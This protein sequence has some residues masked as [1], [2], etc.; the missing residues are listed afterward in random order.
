MTSHRSARYGRYAG[1]PDPLAPPLDL[2]EALAAV[3]QDVMS[4]YSPRQALREFLRRGS[5]T[6]S[7]LDELASRV[8]RRR[9]DLLAEHK[10][11]GTLSEVKRLLDGGV[12]DERKQLARDLDLDDLDREFREL[13]LANLPASTAAAVRELS[14]YDW[15]SPSARA[16]YEQIRDLLGREPVSY[17][18][19]DVYKRQ[20]AAP[21]RRPA[22]ARRAP[23]SGQ[24]SA[25]PAPTV[26][27]RWPPASTRT[28][29]RRGTRPARVRPPTGTGPLPGRAAP[30]RSWAW[31]RA[32]SAGSSCPARWE[33]PCGRAYL[34]A[35]IVP[36]D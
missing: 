17:T 15:R 2:A 1:G 30:R 8:Q 28:G 21:G 31:C 26:R 5:S 33:S 6:A 32:G 14:A 20:P 9:R 27:C 36:P 18:P 24:R 19:L 3:S 23:P 34:R 7:G 22:P 4:G 11:D 16:A 35:G 12:L 10:L 13:R 25:V 29:A